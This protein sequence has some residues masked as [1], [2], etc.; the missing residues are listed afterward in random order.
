MHATNVNHTYSHVGKISRL[1][2]QLFILSVLSYTAFGQAAAEDKNDP[3]TLHGGIEISPRVVRGIA[4]R[5]SNAEEG[6]KI[7]YSNISTIPS[8]YSTDGKLKTEYIRDVARLVQKYLDIMQKE[9]QV[10]LNQ[11]YVIVNSDMIAQNPDELKTEVYGRT[12]KT[13]NFLNAEAEIQLEIAGVIPRRYQV[14]SKMFDNRGVSSLVD[15]GITTTKGGY[16]QLKQTDSGK[17]GYDFSTWDIPKGVNN[18]A[19]EVNRAAGDNADY[20]T[21]ARVAAT[22]SS[23]FKDLLRA[24]AI[25][26]PGLMTRKKLYLTGGIVSAMV[27]LLHTD[28]QRPYIP[29]T[30]NDINAFH[31]RAVSN[32][33][34]LLNPDLSKIHDEKLRTEITK[35]CEAVKSTFTP[36]TLIAGAELLR[37]MAAE[38]MI[39][40]KQVIYQRHSQLA[41][42]L[43]YVRLQP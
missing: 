7:L 14:D 12:G 27:T 4:L 30:L 18:F 25:K 5:I 40:D 43:S 29:I 11:I 21:F 23:S 10:P 28:D 35:N 34:A 26:K 15:I 32:P 24:E 8:A 9:H 42:I 6:L 17:P 31:D 16:Q 13:V 3:K 38:L 2:F 19:D 36:K 33:E 20:R 22:M 41:R 39:W 1:V 37:A